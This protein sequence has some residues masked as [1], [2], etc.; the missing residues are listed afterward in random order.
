[1]AAVCV[2]IHGVCI[3]FARAHAHLSLPA[4]ARPRGAA[5]NAAA[6]GAPFVLQGELRELGQALTRDIY[7]D[8]PN[9]RWEDISGLD[10]AKR[11]IK[12]A[13]V[14]PIKYPQLFT[15]GHGR[16]AAVGCRVQGT[17]ISHM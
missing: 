6:A 9:V 1:M 11:L 16:A 3:E 10:E 4:H 8:S 5:A 13:V 14:M 2:R 15:G 7:Q 17:H 12:E